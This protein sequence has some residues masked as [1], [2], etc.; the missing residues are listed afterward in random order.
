MT[1]AKR[2]GGVVGRE[3]G[4]VPCPLPGPSEMA[5]CLTDACLQY[6]PT[7]LWAYPP[8]REMEENCGREALRLAL[9]PLLSLSFLEERVLVGS[10]VPITSSLSLL[11]SWPGGSAPGDP[12]SLHSQH[13]PLPGKPWL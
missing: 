1:A 5:Q 3:N 9:L 2:G 13:S 7:Q 8:G 6:C 4:S 10:W 11:H 12:G